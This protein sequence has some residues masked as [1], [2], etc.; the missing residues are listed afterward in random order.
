MS[1]LKFAAAVTL[2]ALAQTALHGEKRCPGNLPSV[3]LRVL[4]GALIVA[5]VTINGSGPY[6]FLVDTGAQITTIDS[7]LAEQLNLRTEGV[8]GVS[9][10]ADFGRKNFVRLTQAEIGGHVVNDVLAV[11]DDLVQ[12]HHADE[13][14]RGIVGED[15]L[16]HFDLLIDNRH[17]MFCLDATGTMAVE[18]KGAHVA[19]EQ[20]YGPDH[21]MPFTRPLVFSARLGGGGNALLFRLDSGSNA[22]VIYA[23]RGRERSVPANAQILK[24]SVNGAEQGFAVLEP[25]DLDVGSQ[26]VRRVSFVQPMNSAGAASVHREDGVLPTALFQSVFVSYQSKFAILVP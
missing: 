5:P 25:Q 13:K 8:T 21:D 2:T 11:V 7:R 17:Q 24:T 15:Y 12:L 23:E 10:V 18:I 16:A 4:Q 22:P 14:I 9:G 3:P 20:P 6:D 1:I 26:R 19:L